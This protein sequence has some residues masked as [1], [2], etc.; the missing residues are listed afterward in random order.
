MKIMIT[1]ASGLLGRACKI[2]FADL[3]PVTCAWSRAQ[4]N[5]LKLDLTNA[6]E[7]RSAL[8]EI[9]PDLIIH[10]AA[11]RKPD[12]CEN[13][14]DITQQLNVEATHTLATTTAAI[15][16]TL[17]YLSTD[18]VFDGTQPPYAVDAQ[19]NPLNF[20]GQT[21]LAGEKATL[22]ASADHIVL[23]VPILYGE[24]ETLDESP[25]TLMLHKLLD[26]TPVV[27]DHWALRYPT[28]VGD[29]AQTLRNWLPTLGN[30]AGIYHFSGSEALTKF[31]MLNRMGKNLNLST[32]HITANS[33]PP[34]GAPR[35]QNSQLDISRLKNKTVLQQTPFSENIERILKPFLKGK[36]H[37]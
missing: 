35:P 13:Q 5:D 2:A 8:Q 3:H 15:G 18:Y 11:E 36:N 37:E 29:V 20:Y 33:E 1:G 7:V 19:T 14:Q 26:P 31:E 30:S 4:E 16:A 32:E 28:Y 34:S 22:E 6:S 25:V 10:T 27:E 9:K 24:V 21:K 17:I 12:I 23:R